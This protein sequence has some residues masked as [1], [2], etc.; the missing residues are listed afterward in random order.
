MAGSAFSRSCRAP[1]GKSLSPAAAV[2]TCATSAMPAIKTPALR[3]DILLI[4][5]NVLLDQQPSMWGVALDSRLLARWRVPIK[6]TECPSVS[7][8]IHYVCSLPTNDC[9]RS[10]IPVIRKWNTR[11]TIQEKYCRRREHE[12]GA[13]K[14][15][16]PATRDTI[17]LRENC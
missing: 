11:E 4:T 7:V 1:R 8:C 13:R 2:P 12:R 14:K 3:F 17:R 5:I 16:G 9:P 15:G 6:T 10:Y